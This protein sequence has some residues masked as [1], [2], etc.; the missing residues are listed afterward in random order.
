MTQYPTLQI[1]LNMLD[2]DLR[3]VLSGL[4]KLDRDLKDLGTGGLSQRGVRTLLVNKV[5]IIAN[6]I[7]SLRQHLSDQ[8]ILDTWIQYGDLRDQSDQLYRE[9]LEI[10]GGVA[11]RQR[12]IDEKI[13]LIA[14]ELV[15]GA[16][17]DPPSLTILTTA[18][19]YVPN[20]ARLMRI[21]FSD[22][23]VWTL[24]LTAHQFAH[25]LI[26]DYE[27][28]KEVA[29][30]KAKEEVAAASPES[31][32]TDADA[33]VQRKKVVIRRK[34]LEAAA[35]R[36]EQLIAD[37]IALY[38]VGPCYAGSALLF[39]FSPVA[40]L[41]EQDSQAPDIERAHVCLQ[42]L[43]NLNANAN[44]KNP[45]LEF[46]E[47]LE[48]LWNQ[49]LVDAGSANVLTA[50]RKAVLD[51]FVKQLYKVLDQN[52][53]AAQYPA[54]KDKFS[55][56]LGGWSVAAEWVR[57][58]EVAKT[59]NPAE[60]MQV[61]QKVDA[62]SKVRDALNAA[63]LYRSKVD[64]TVVPELTNVVRQ[65]CDTII[66]QLYKPEEA[67]LTAVASGPTGIRAR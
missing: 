24:P 63:W 32:A 26:E 34:L 31:A 58:W 8:P 18:D 56:E 15:R 25:V 22:R 46:I 13:C 38:I 40:G 29:K 27:E 11:I 51:N 41:P 9:F 28:F 2:E 48:A 21:R 57:D 10:V 43:R 3:T 23:A 55:E 65:M 45:Y 37:C 4:D 30:A 16:V 62:S 1:R 60:I 54:Y 6:K 64:E 7:K 20:L 59:N 5:K 66:K 52:L 67:S 36:W 39:R 14:Q 47:W 49:L 33:E 53:P 42:M 61:P 50:E 17:V 19:N 44:V 12:E 35:S